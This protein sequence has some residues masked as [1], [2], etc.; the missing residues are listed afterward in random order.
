MNEWQQT[1]MNTSVTRTSD[2]KDITIT[3]KDLE[4]LKNNNHSFGEN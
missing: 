3:K 2:E 1:R 4:I